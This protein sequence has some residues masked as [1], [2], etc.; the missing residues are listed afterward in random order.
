MRS[1][2]TT[3]STGRS[4]VNTRSKFETSSAART[5]G[6]YSGSTARRS[7]ASQSSPWKNGCALTASNPPASS[8]PSRVA[9]LRRRNPCIN[10]A[11]A[12]DIEDS[13]AGRTLGFTMF[14]S[15]AKWLAPRNGC[16][17]VNISE[18]KIPMHQKSTAWPWPRCSSTSGAMYCSVPQN[19]CVV[20]SSTASSPSRPPAPPAPPLA[21]VELAE[22]G[23]EEPLPSAS[24]SSPSGPAPGSAGIT[25]RFCSKNRDRPKSVSLIWPSLSRSTFSGLRSRYTMPCLCR[26]CSARSSSAM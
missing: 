4:L 22:V 15:V 20:S 13:V 2:S 14:F 26:W 16:R 5:R 7:A 10:D 12:G 24:M 17:P 18:N 25:V 8:E 9:T 11:A 19:E 6:L 1:P 23:E 21:S 3:E